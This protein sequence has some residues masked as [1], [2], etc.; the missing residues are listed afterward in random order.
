MK[1][2]GHLISGE[3]EFE[4]SNTINLYNPNNAE[5]I[6]KVSLASPK[7]IDKVILSSMSALNEWKSYSISKRSSIL[8]EYKVLLEKNI[9]KIADIIG[10]DLGKVKDDAIGEIRRGI[11]N[12]EYA[13]GIGEILKGE[14]NKNIST[15]VDS[16]SE[17][18]PLGVVLGVTPFNFPTMVPL[19]MFP[20]ALAAGNSFILKPSEKDPLSTMFIA[21]LFNETG[22]PKGL[23]N[24]INGNK[25]TV[26]KLIEDKRIR[27]V[28]FVGST[29]V[30]KKIYENSGKYGKRCQALGGAKN[31][32]LVLSDANLEYTTNQLISAAFGSS[33]QRCMALSVAMVQR[34]IKDKFIE[35]LKKKTNTLRVGFNIK[36]SNSFGPL[37]T[38]EHMEKVRDFIDMAESEGCEII[39]DGR[40]INKGKNSNNG[41]Y[42]GATIINNVKTNMTSYQNEIFGPVL[43]IIEVENMENAIE[44]INENRFGN[45]C[46]IFT[47]NGEYARKFSNNINIGMVGINIPL[48]VP[49][50]FH[51]FGGWKES[52]FGDLNI[53]GPDGLRFYTQ[54]KTITQ[55]WPESK[56]SESNL[57]LSMPD[58]LN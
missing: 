35:I 15:S 25:E 8:F 55:R 47:S 45:G 19:W 16:W 27:A 23:L 14:Y 11:E 34:N 29:P 3:E 36:D 7:I 40:N 18:E 30:A 6:G 57:D 37:V 2:I 49:S 24:I 13:C 10:E 1:E 56:L 20:L 53:Y 22:A 9:N 58:N 31:H 39:V 51:S 4:N 33:G 52:L 41:Y 5:L 43:Q 17:F 38:L 28:S 54:R 21:K 42:L 26:E 46:C 12:V 50:S 32:A 44:I 48:P